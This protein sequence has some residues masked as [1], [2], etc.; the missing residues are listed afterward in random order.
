MNEN[1]QAVVSN[2]ATRLPG[3]W[4]QVQCVH[5]KTHSSVA[6]PLYKS[7][8]ELPSRV[9]I[10]GSAVKVSRKRL[11]DSSTS[12]QEEVPEEGS[13]VINEDYCLKTEAKKVKR[14]VSV[15][16]SS[17]TQPLRVRGSR[18]RKPS[19]KLKL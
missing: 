18:I 2:L 6:L 9:E 14:I 11:P 16:K 3:G 8:P 13:D 7:L 1:L 19:K 5:I 4:K 15:K 12:D 17:K 10:E